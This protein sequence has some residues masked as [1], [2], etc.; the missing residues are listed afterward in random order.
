M[1]LFSKLGEGR[2]KKAT[3]YVR[4]QLGTDEQPEAVLPMTQTS[5]PLVPGARFYGI[6]VL[7]N[8]VVLLSYP[9]LS[10]TPNAI[11]ADWDRDAV[12]IERWKG[13]VLEIRHPEGTARLEVPGMHRKDAKALV[14]ALGG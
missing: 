13:G 4:D 12:A 3:A 11:V 2:R 10:E 7:A 1:G 8:R 6:V 14:A 5:N 9:K